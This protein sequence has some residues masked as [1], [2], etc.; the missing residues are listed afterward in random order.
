MTVGVE[1]AI[2]IQIHACAGR[3]CVVHLAYMRCVPSFIKYRASTNPFLLSYFFLLRPT[4]Q[5]D[6][7][8]P[9]LPVRSYYL[10]AG[11][12]LLLLRLVLMKSVERC[13]SS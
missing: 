10:G 3:Q 8:L 13:N 6:S 9:C 7:V 11:V 1:V 2:H 5:G 4:F 12:I